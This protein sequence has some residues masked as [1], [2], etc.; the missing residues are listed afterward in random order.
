METLLFYCLQR[1]LT[2]SHKTLLLPQTSF[3]QHTRLNQKA[4]NILYNGDALPQKPNGGMS[5]LEVQGLV[6]SMQNP[7]K[8]CTNLGSG[9]VLK[10]V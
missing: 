1:R 6:V 5:S 3:E 9:N 4:R 8:N 2:L 7:F 10:Y